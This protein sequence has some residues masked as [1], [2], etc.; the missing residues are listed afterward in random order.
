MDKNYAYIHRS[1]GGRRVSW[2][3][4]W[5]IHQRLSIGVRRRDLFTI[6][7]IWRNTKV[8]FL[9]FPNKKPHAVKVLSDS[10]RQCTP[11]V[12]LGPCQF[13]VA[14]RLFP[15]LSAF[16]M[17]TF[18]TNNSNDSEFG[19]YFGKFSIDIYRFYLSILAGIF[20]FLG[21]WDLTPLPF[22]IF[23]KNVFS[24][25]INQKLI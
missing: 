17:T 16:G 25:I 6:R 8:Y 22:R 1:G 19:V 10:P 24:K 4:N 7:N 13:P 12:C 23:L 5:W 3:F 20:V 18:Q 14:I 2:K 9:F 15:P 11:R 21:F